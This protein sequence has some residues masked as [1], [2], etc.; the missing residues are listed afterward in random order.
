MLRIRLITWPFGQVFG[1][2]HAFSL[3]SSTKI[4]NYTHTHK[5]KSERN[6]DEPSLI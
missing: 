5:K 3:C 2:L 6:T 1:T 4:L